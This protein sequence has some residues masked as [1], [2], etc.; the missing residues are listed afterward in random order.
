MRLGLVQ[1]FEASKLIPSDIPPPT[2]PHFLILH[3]QPTNC[4]LSTQIYE[5]I[6]AIF[7]HTTTPV[8]KQLKQESV[9]LCSQLKAIFHHGGEV[10]V[11]GA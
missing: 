4:G 11:T 2:M 8:K 9:D 1:I 5:P 6:G 10:K 7:I 3:E